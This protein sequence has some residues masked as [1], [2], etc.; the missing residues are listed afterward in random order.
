DAAEVWALT[1]SLTLGGQLAFGAAFAWNEIG[2]VYTAEA[3]GAR[4]EALD[5]L[6]V[7]AATSGA[8]RTLTAAGAL[9]SGSLAVTGAGAY[10]IIDAAATAR[11]ANAEIVPSG[12]TVE[13]TASDDSDIIAVAA[14][15][16][17][18]TGSSA[19]AGAVAVS[20][21]RGTLA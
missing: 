17:V 3:S 8:I 21:A 6:N 4:F 2:N 16:G 12:A 19:G 14:S 5:T 9:S 20:E 13:V 11:I 18:S 15:L 10:S 7:D 1:G